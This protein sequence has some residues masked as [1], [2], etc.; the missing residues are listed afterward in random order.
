[1]VSRRLPVL[2]MLSLLVVF[3]LGTTAWAAEGG[4]STSM[5]QD[6][7]GGGV[8]SVMIMIALFMLP[9]FKRLRIKALYQYIS[10]LHR[11]KRGA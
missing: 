1:M 8:F 7:F 6:M 11:V 10:C 4:P 2:L 5:L 9:E 3:A